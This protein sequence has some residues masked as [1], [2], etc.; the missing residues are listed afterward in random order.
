MVWGFGIL[1]YTMIK[2]ILLRKGGIFIIM[3]INDGKR[4]ATDNIMSYKHPG[5]ITWKWQWEILHEKN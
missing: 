3:V 1:T 5:N 4:L 2:K